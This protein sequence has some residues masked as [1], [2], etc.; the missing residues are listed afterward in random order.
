MSSIRQQLVELLHE[1]TISGQMK[2]NTYT[3]I[4]AD[5]KCVIFDSNN[6]SKKVIIPMDIVIEWV[7]ALI[8]RGIYLEYKSRLKRDIITKTS[9]W[10]TTNH[11]F[12]SHLNAIL[13][14]YN[15]EFLI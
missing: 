3:C 15:N 5:Y 1:K 13:H 6:K 2:N 8:D 12:E 9:P 11:S 10:S 14:A 7:S 4:H